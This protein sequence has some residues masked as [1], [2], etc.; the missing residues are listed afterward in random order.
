MT[1]GERGRAPSGE[2]FLWQGDAC[3]PSRLR[4]PV[5]LGRSFQSAIEN[6]Q[7]AMVLLSDDLSI[8]VIQ[9]HITKGC[10]LIFHLVVV[11]DDY[12]R[13]VIRIEIL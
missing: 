10:N 9:R 13:G 3:P 12:D 8:R 6:S 4:V 5:E 7:Y 11:A 1:G 2:S